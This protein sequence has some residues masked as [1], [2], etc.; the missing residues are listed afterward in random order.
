MMVAMLVV[1]LSGYQVQSYSAK[2]ILADVLMTDLLNRMDKDMQVG[3]YDVGNEA[4]AGSKDN[5]DL[6]SRSEY[7]RLCDGGS[8]CILQSGSASGAASIL[9]C[10]MT[11]FCS[12]VRCGVTSSSPAEWERVPTGIPL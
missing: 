10:G 4:A 11:S 1:A 8:D 2:D 12:T 3:Y 5:V 6:V 7:A 9:R